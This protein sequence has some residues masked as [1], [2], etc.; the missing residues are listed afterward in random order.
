MMVVTEQT[1]AD[2]LVQDTL[3]RAL[4]NARLWRPGSD[5]RAW[6]YTIMRNR[7]F[8]VIAKSSRS[9]LELQNVPAAASG[10]DPGELRLTCVIWARHCVACRRTNARPFC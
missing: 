1:D 4:A 7:F 9:V 5:L 3:V 6:L 10:P 8:A 2:D